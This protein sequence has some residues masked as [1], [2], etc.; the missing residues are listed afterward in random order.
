MKVCPDNKILNPKSNQCIN[1]GTQLHKSLIKEGILDKDTLGKSKKKVSKPVSSNNSTQFQDL[2]NTSIKQCTKGKVLNPQS[3]HCI[4]IGSVTYNKLV[5]NGVLSGEEEIKL[6]KDYALEVEFVKDDKKQPTYKVYKKEP[7]DDKEQPKLFKLSPNAKKLFLGKVKSFLKKKNK[8]ILEINKDVYDNE[9]LHKKS[10]LPTTTIV[11]N[12]ITMKYY[13]RNYFPSAIKIRPFHFF[14]PNFN[15]QKGNVITSDITI[16]INSFTKRYFENILKLPLSDVMNKQLLDYE[17]LNECNT[18]IKRLS[19][20]DKFTLYA[21]SFHGDRYVNNFLRGTLNASRVKNA[22]FQYISLEV[23]NPLFF[24]YI[25]SIGMYED[26]FKQTP[27]QY[28]KYIDYCKSISSLSPQNIISLV[29]SYNDRLS[30]II[31]KAPML[32][33]RM[34]LFRGTKDLYFNK[35]EPNKPFIHNGYMSAT[36]D[37][38]VS[39]NPA[40][41]KT[42]SQGNQCC[43]MVINVLP[44]TRM[45]PLT[46]LSQVNSEKEFL[47]NTNS[48][49]MVSEQSHKVEKVP[50]ADICVKNTET[51][52][53]THVFIG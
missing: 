44:G 23:F 25:H 19:I 38:N 47:L 32:K 24:E 48:K 49:I 41:S 46:G 4:T 53:V 9:C 36:I 29:K 21:Y 17:W 28:R 12:R 8:N 16:N 45:I 2:T 15:I 20:I 26:F 42:D 14:N 51:L 34:T 30:S 43:L 27:L 11:M 31:S 35:K 1:R 52:N 39:L 18:Y 40:F 6:K 37:F 7:K 3:N 33:Q 10:I 50:A 13:S 22:F 5:K